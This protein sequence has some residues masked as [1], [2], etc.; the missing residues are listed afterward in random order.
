MAECILLKSSDQPELDGLTAVPS[1]VLEG[2]TFM[3]YG[4]EEIQAGAIPKKGSPAI[5]IPINGSAQLEYGYYTGGTVS[6]NIP[7]YSGGNVGYGKEQVTINTSGKYA[8]GNIVLPA[9]KGLTPDVIKKG[10]YVGGV[11]PGTW[12]GYVNIDP[13]SLYYRGAYQDGQSIEWLANG[14]LNPSITLAGRNYTKGTFDEMKNQMKISLD[15][16]S[17]GDLAAVTADTV[18]LAFGGEVDFSQYSKIHLNMYV[19]EWNKNRGIRLALFKKLV[20]TS[21]LLSSGGAIRLN[22]S[23]GDDLLKKYGVDTSDSLDHMQYTYVDFR[24]DNV[25]PGIYSVD[26]SAVQESGYMYL[27]FCDRRSYS[28]SY[29]ATEYNLYEV[30]MKK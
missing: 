23:L 28:S 18:V 6:Q 15:P 1:D 16:P 3:G 2:E 25:E 12:E 4:S 9:I 14:I 30:N 29:T 13:D 22:S 11:G 10:A 5:T 8:S 21:L 24:E 20:K 7:V 26:I 19:E 27:I 17:R